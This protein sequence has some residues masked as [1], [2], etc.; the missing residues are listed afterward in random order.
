M[1]VQVYLETSNG[2]RLAEALHS[3]VKL[4]IMVTSKQLKFIL[5]V[6]FWNVVDIH[7]S[8]PGSPLCY[9]LEKFILAVCSL[10]FSSGT[11]ISDSKV[12]T[13]TYIC[14]MSVYVY[15]K[16]NNFPYLPEIVVIVHQ[17]SREVA[18]TAFFFFFP[19]LVDILKLCTLF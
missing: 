10:P 6:F 5:Y 3:K 18:A 7:F 13:S 11:V 14:Y 19:K 4:F 8:L 9:I 15:V 2:D 17:F 12:Q 1:F 16:H